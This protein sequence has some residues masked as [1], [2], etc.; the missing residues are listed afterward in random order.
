ML[1]VYIAAKGYEGAIGGS[2]NQTDALDPTSQ[3]CLTKSLQ[4]IITLRL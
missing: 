3:N 2:L 1:V 4:T